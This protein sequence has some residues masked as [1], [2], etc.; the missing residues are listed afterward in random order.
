MLILTCPHCGSPPTKPIFMP[1]GEAHLKRHGPGSSEADF[2][3]Y[4]F[5]RENPK[6]VHFERWRHVYGCG[7]WFLAARNTATLEVF[8][9]Y[10]AQTHRAAAAISRRHPEGARL[11]PAGDFPRR[12]PPTNEHRLAH[13]RPAGRPR[14]GRCISLQ[15]QAHAGLRGRHAGQRAAGERPDADGP[16]VQVPPPA[17]PRRRGRGRAERAG[18]TGPRRGRSRTSA[19]RRSNF[20]TA[21]SP[22]ARTTGPASNSTWA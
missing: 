21:S 10:P 12:N 15:R 3:N 22:A 13:Q 11:A 9:T 14:T 6:G 7:K 8:G 17:R 16:V 18:G 2:E 4:L 5:M 19:S 20:T 1:G